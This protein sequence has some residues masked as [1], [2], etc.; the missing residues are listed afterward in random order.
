[1]DNARPMVLTSTEVALR[2]ALAIAF[3]AA[4]GLERELSGHPAGLRTHILVAIGACLYTLAGFTPVAFGVADELQTR[5]DVTR[6]A[7][8]V[9]VGIGF[10]GGGTIL[11]HGATVRGLTTAAN[12]WVTAALGLAAGMG[13]Y[14]GAIFSAC[15]VLFVLIA[16][17]PF[18][19]WIQ[20]RRARSGLAE[21]H[22]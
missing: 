8:Q 6:V 16:L 18:E 3:G 19:A 17:R 4:V 13:M 2:L 21:E 11:R 20:R 1:M 12:L 10:L 5:L 15:A 22:D 14:G 9:V 7:S